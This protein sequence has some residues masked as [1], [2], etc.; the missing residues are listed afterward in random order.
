M[1]VNSRR[2]RDGVIAT[3]AAA[4]IVILSP[5]VAIAALVGVLVLAA[6]GVTV[7]WE[8]R[9]TRRLRRLTRQI[10]RPRPHRR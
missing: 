3:I 6:C 7:L 5:G 9:A 2:L 8:R 1:N 4:L 10:R